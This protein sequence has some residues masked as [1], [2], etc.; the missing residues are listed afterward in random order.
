MYGQLIKEKRKGL[1]LTQAQFAYRCGLSSATIA[2]IEQGRHEATFQTRQMIDNF[3]YPNHTEKRPYGLRLN[4]RRKEHG[5]TLI[6]LAAK[7]KSN[8]SRLS[9]IEHGKIRPSVSLHMRL[10]ELLGEI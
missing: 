8:A 6:Q 5:Y 9:E 2:G 7:V 1:K 10:R 3:L 4:I